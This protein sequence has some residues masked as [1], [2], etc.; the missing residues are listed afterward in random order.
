M[1][2]DKSHKRKVINVTCIKA[3]I[4][5]T[6]T[7]NQSKIKKEKRRDKMYIEINNSK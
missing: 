5:Y 2:S 4:R 1:S 3:R 6:V 7:I